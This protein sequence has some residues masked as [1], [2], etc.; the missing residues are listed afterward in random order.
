MDDTEQTAD[1]EVRDVP[2]QSR[3]ELVDDGVV[4][5]IADYSVRDGVAV[6]PHTVIDHDRRGQGLG[7]VLVAAAVAELA[8]RGLR[9]DAQCWFVFDYLSRT[10]GA[11]P[12]A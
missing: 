8:G 10:P 3:F 11:A 4:I 1:L 12:A 9:I 7:D 5:G 6:M 2:A